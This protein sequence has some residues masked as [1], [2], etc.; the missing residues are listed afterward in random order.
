[1]RNEFIDQLLVEARDDPR[2]M[3][4][5]GDLGYGVI[6]LYSRELPKQFLNA[7]VAEQSMIGLAAGLSTFGYK[8]VVY[9]IGNFPTLRALEQVRND[10]CY[11]CLDVAIVS[12][13]AGFAYG[14]LG[15]THHAIE[16]ISVMRS[17]P[18]LTVICPADPRE[19]RAAISNF[20]LNGGPTYIRLDKASLNRVHME[21][22]LPQLKFPIAVRSGE[23]LSIIATGSV[24]AN[25][26][27]ASD[28]LLR[29]GFSVEVL[30]CHTVTPLD[31]DWLIKR[32]PRIPVLTVEEHVLPG[33]FG[34]T[35]LE[36]ANS[37]ASQTPVHRLGIGGSAGRLGGSQRYLQE[38]FGLSPVAIAQT[39]KELIMHHKAT[40]S[41]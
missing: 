31:Q 35:V 2:L 40:E 33:G 22:D 8:V 1:M 4:V 23:D 34:S 26:I 7:G 15:Y 38:A 32:S 36:A 6:D 16:D 30:S 18:N 5:V 28:L 11:H 29:E 24:V 17:L 14:S 21:D 37:V 19:A 12:V 10:V 13:G 3:L 39:A 25:C 41:A 20:A 9:S 27:E